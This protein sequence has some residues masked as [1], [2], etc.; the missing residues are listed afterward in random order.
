MGATT[1]RSGGNVRQAIAVLDFGK[2][3]AKLTLFSEAG[4]RLL[5]LDSPTAPLRQTKPWRLDLAGL[6][7]WAWSALAVAAREAEIIAIVPVGHGA[8]A[9]L[10]DGDRPVTALDYED[11]PPPEIAVA[12]EALRD[13][14]E[15]TL[16]PSLPQDLNLG[17][18]LFWLEKLH[19]DLWPG[20]GQALLWP[21]Y[22]AWRLSG[23]RASEVTSLGC[24]S[25]LWRPL[26]GRFS[27]LA[28]ARGWAERVGPLRRAGDALGPVRA[29]VAEQLG[30]SRRCL[31][32]AGLHDSNAA[33]LAARAL[34]EVAAKAFAAVSTGTWFVCMSSGG[35]G[36]ALYDPGKDMLANVDVDGRAVPTARFMGGRDYVEAMG[37]GLGAAADPSRLEEAAAGCAPVI[38]RHARG[39]GVGP[40]D[41]GCA[42]TDCCRRPGSARGPLRCRPGLRR[43]PQASPPGP[44]GARQLSP[45]RRRLG[46]AGSRG[47]RF[48]AGMS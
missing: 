38:A 35:E 5:Q 9:V 8:A 28:L 10:V 27:D 46:R 31:V 43:R 11:E 17:R 3:R 41:R 40:Q 1:S 47:R 22:W 36:P 20:S 16:S 19:P 45:R 7:R 33:L 29:E 15:A 30:L 4:E 14:F 25:D 2:T 34:P 48:S 6:E 24:H 26:E 18:Q 13:P 42:R 23:E 21:Q 39:R 44:S 32:H 37:D 12:Y